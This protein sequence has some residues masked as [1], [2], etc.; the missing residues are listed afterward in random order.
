MSW[1]LRG[2]DVLAAVENRPAGLARGLPRDEMQGVVVV[3]GLSFVHT[4]S[5]HEPFD[6]AR[7]AART[8]DEGRELVEVRKIS[9]LGAHRVALPPLGKGTMVI[10]DHGA[11]ERWG[12]RI[13]DRL[14]IK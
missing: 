13:G 3:A 6:V 14:E 1:L 10:A 7:C 11:F 2:S 12:L 9:R 8:D 5:C 4:F